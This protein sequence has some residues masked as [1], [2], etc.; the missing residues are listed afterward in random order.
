[1]KGGASSHVFVF[2]LRSGRLHRLVSRTSVLAH[3]ECVL[4]LLT[5]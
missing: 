3:D 5:T 4:H 2:E 1:M